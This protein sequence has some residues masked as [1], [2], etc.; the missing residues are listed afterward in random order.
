MAKAK[1]ALPGVPAAE[2]SVVS[3]EEA[4]KKASVRAAKQK[5][6][7]QNIVTVANTYAMV[8]FKNIAGYVTPVPVSRRV[9]KIY[10]IPELPAT[11]Y[12]VDAKGKL[13]G[14]SVGDFK[15]K[16]IKISRGYVLKE[17]KTVTSG[18]KTGIGKKSISLTK[19]YTRVWT[20]LRVPL[21]ASA[22]DVI[23]WMKSWKS[24]KKPDMLKIGAQTIPTGLNKTK[25]A[26][27]AETLSNKEA[28]E[29]A[30]SK[31]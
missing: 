26:H 10:G 16:R 1:G 12:K 23:F 5:N 4:A 28:A 9:A 7:K 3:L 17:R 20:S 27:A 14:K 8:A 13:L 29:L 2:D 15:G 24:G 22:L 19:T 25:A 21:G 30:G 11:E 6:K 31:A 18:R